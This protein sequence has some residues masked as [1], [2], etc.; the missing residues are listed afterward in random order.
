MNNEINLENMVDKLNL[1]KTEFIKDKELLKVSIRKDVVAVELKAML[2]TNTDFNSL[3]TAIL[4]YI[5]ALYD[6]K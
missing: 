3:K 4:Q 6:I 1:V 2:D 5:D